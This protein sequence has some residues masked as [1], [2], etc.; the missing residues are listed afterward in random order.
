MGS[1]TDMYNLMNKFDS[2]DQKLS[3]ARIAEWQQKEATKKKEKEEKEKI[4]LKEKHQKRKQ[5]EIKKKKK[6]QKKKSK[7]L[8]QDSKGKIQDISIPQKSRP[9]S[10]L[11]SCLTTLFS[12]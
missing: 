9:K 6:R 2:K 1:F 11:L 3:A 8:D 7:K 5:K 12:R 10:S 4:A